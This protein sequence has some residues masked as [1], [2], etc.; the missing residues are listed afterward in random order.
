MAHRKRLRTSQGAECHFK[1]A[2][3]EN[4]AEDLDARPPITRPLKKLSLVHISTIDQDV[5]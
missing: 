2:P 3:P 5:G 1:N 4:L